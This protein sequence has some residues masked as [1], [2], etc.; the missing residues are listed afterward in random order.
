MSD[1]LNTLIHDAR[2]WQGRRHTRTSLPSHST[3][4]AALDRQ[5][6]DTGW[7]IGALS[8]CLVDR[9][10]I[11]EL[12][13]VLPVLKKVVASGKVAFWINP[14]CV[15]YAPALARSGIDLEQVVVIHTKN[16]GDTL[17]TLENCLRS[18]VT[19]LVFAWPGQLASRDIRRLQLAAEAGRNVCVLF[20]PRQQAQHSSPAALRL[21]LDALSESELQ[22]QVLKRRG[23]WP[24]PPCNLELNGRSGRQAHS[25]AKVIAGPWAGSAG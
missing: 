12:Q 1:L 14:P 8:E 22:V 11:G 4:H 15:P 18:T 24:T 19:G 20:R 2:I 23:G 5:L 16:P 7:P 6:D 3:G 17:W 21:E 13:L 10:G 9:P 25:A